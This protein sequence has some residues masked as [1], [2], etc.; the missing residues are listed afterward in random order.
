MVES[1]GNHLTR[2]DAGTHSE[3]DNLWV[4]CN[5]LDTSWNGS[6]A[7]RDKVQRERQKGTWNL[8]RILL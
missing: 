8:H 5:G 3:G 1:Q 2:D 6:S 4:R 7:Y